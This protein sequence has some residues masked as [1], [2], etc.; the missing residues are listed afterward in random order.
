MRKNEIT[1]HYLTI[2]ETI[3]AKNDNIKNLKVQLT[4]VENNIYNVTKQCKV[5]KI[6]IENVLDNMNDSILNIQK[7]KNEKLNHLQKLF[8]YYKEAKDPLE[9][10]THNMLAQFIENKKKLIDERNE[11]DY[12][13]Q[14][15]ILELKKL[16][17]DL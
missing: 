10:Q 13:I 8:E 9:N 17:K 5:L 6:K 7:T 11:L 12:Q 4:N 2:N 16:K 15:K 14:V 1:K 3:E